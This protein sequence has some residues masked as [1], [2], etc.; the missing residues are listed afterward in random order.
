MSSAAAAIA[1]PC[2]PAPSVISRPTRWVSAT[3]GQACDEPNGVIVPRSYPVAALATAA[4]G[5]DSRLTPSVARS[6]G[7]EMARSPGTSTKIKSLSAR[8]IT[9]VLTTAAGAT[10]LARAASARLR[11][12]PCVITR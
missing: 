2:S 6:F 4:S 1:T 7:Q 9:R 10:L 11:T 5:S 8:L 3:T 12:G